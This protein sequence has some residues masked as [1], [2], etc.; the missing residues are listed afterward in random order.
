MKFRG[1]YTNTNLNVREHPPP[2]TTTPTRHSCIPVCE[3]DSFTIGPAESAL[4]LHIREA[5][6]EIFL[7][8]QPNKASQIGLLIPVKDIIKM[9]VKTKSFTQILL[10]YCDD[11]IFSLIPC[12]RLGDK[13]LYRIKIPYEQQKK[14]R[15]LLF[16]SRPHMLPNHFAAWCCVSFSTNIS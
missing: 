9:Q 13:T 7:R 16:N 11:G 15:L 1:H 8:P 10:V 4:I 12:F 3:G 2:F 6:P 5:K 14:A